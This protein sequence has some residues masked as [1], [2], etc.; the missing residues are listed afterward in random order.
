MPNSQISVPGTTWH[1]TS[2]NYGYSEKLKFKVLLTCYNL[3]VNYYQQIS[4]DTFMY[5]P[6]F[7]LCFDIPLQVIH[8]IAQ[9]YHLA[10]SLPHSLFSVI[11]EPKC[12]V[13]SIACQHTSP[14]LMQ[15]IPK[16]TS[17]ST[18]NSACPQLLLFLKGIEKKKSQSLS[19][20]N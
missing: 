1:S 2:W 4:S 9:F 6:M 11:L 19:T 16:N 18:P 5:W 15:K 10:L 7:F 8:S 13:T 12:S 14:G 20:I 17:D 3:P